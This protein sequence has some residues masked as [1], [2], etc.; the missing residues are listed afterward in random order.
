[1]KKS[2]L[3]FICPTLLL[4]VLITLYPLF[5]IMIDVKKIEN[6]YFSLGAILL[7]LL[8]ILL[9]IVLFVEEIY[10]IYYLYTKT[11]L[12][13]H[14]KLIWTFILLVFNVL[15]IPLYYMKFVSKESKCFVK[16]LIYIMPIIVLSIVFMFG[17]KSYTDDI[18][19][20]KAERKRIEAERNVYKTKDNVVSFTFK[21]GYKQEQVGE[22]DLYVKNSQKKVLL[23]AFTYDTTLY[24][25]TTP[26][27]YI[28]KAISDIS[29][30][31]VKFDVYK[32]KEVK[33]MDDKTITSVE[34]IGNTKES[35]DCIYKITIITFKNK[36][37]YLVYA[38]G[39]VTKVNYKLYNKEINEIIETSKLN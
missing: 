14:Q 30:D 13:I 38:V 12:K 18:N 3:L 21:H 17:Y 24:E 34:Y 16:T 27:Q 29:K 2:K 32:Q 10:L 25:Q 11:D 26:D 15:A 31:K 37:D 23:T 5:K 22:Y 6:V 28:G 33:E 20:I 7:L 4:F 36:P 8:F 39:V 35:S 9:C 1:M 19:K